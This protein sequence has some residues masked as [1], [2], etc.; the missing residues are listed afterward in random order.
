M[1][2][3]KNVE[4]VQHSVLEKELEDVETK[5]TTIIEELK[6][7][8]EEIQKLKENALVLTGAK[9]ILTKLVGSKST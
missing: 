4:H 9:A 3:S 5:Y 6:K 7:R 8:N 2:E 1:E